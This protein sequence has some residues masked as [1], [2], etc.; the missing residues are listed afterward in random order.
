MYNFASFLFIAN[1]FLC[2]KTKV[3]GCSCLLWFGKPGPNRTSGTRA[4]ENRHMQQKTNLIM[5]SDFLCG[6]PYHWSP[7][8]ACNGVRRKFSWGW[9]GSESYGGHLYLVCAVCDV[10]IWRHVHVSKPTFRRSLLTLYAHFSTSTPL[11]LCVIALNI[12]Y[13]RS[14]LGYRRKTTLT[15]RHNSS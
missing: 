14:K 12:N 10:T 9:V 4:K 5:A 8:G 1:V 15:L 3:I 13:E 11:I 2:R 7:S 6:Y